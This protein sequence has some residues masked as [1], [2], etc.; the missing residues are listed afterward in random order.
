MKNLLNHYMGWWMY[1]LVLCLFEGCTEEE[2][3]G[4]IQESQTEKE[5]YYVTVCLDDAVDSRLALYPGEKGV[6]SVWTAG[7]GFTLINQEDNVAYTF[8]LEK[9]AGTSKGVFV[10]H[11][12]EPIQHAKEKWSLFYPASITSQEEY[13]NQVSLLGQVQKGDGNMEHLNER[14]SMRHQIRH[15]SDI[16]L[17]NTSYKTTFV[18]PE[19]G[20]QVTGTTNPAYLYKNRILKIDASNLPVDM[21]PVSLNL[22]VFNSNVVT[23]VNANGSYSKQ[24]YDRTSLELQEFDKDKDFIAYMAQGGY[25][26][27]IFPAESILRLSVTDESGE[28][29]YSDKFFEENDTIPSGCLLTLKY[30]DGWKRGNNYNYRSTDFSSDGQVVQ[31]QQATVENGINVVFMGD[32]FSDRQI[33]DGLYEEVMKQGYEAFFVEEPFKSFRHYFNIYYV[34]AVSEQEGVKYQFD[35]NNTNTAFK[36]YFGEGTHVSGDNNI[37]KQYTY[38]V[39]ALSN[40]HQDFLTSVVMINSAEY[41]G[42]CQMSFPIEEYSSGQGYAVGYFPAMRDPYDLVQVLNH[43][44][45]GHGFGKLCDEYVNERLTTYSAAEY[46]Q[47]ECKWYMNVD[48]QSDPSLSLWSEFYVGDYITKEGIGAYLGANNAPTSAKYYRPTYNSIMR[49]NA[50]GFNAPSRKE[51]Y[52]RMH[53]LVYGEEWTW[54]NH[55]DE[56]LAWDVMF[57]MPDHPTAPE[58]SAAPGTYISNVGEDGGGIVKIVKEFVPLAPPVIIEKKP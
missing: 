57:G 41:A 21:Q 25:Y 8:E 45:N 53:K 46:Y 20:E 31:L 4:N 12:G 34:V 1:F 19:T 58:S 32:G 37:V 33:A 43:E 35:S 18:N 3:S 11:S 52:V 48:R 39:P 15:Y 51:I 16:R 26:K 38:K 23:F 42:T 49:D 36:T 50:D 27:M 30:S 55:K 28:T 56:F 29:Y 9:G 22:Q 47:K 10:C 6:K 14:L 5:P 44:A 40:V 2:I 17:G 54:E 24:D 7:D 13:E